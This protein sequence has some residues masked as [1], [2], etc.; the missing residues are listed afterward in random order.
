[1]NKLEFRMFGC[2]IP[3]SFWDYGKYSVYIAGS[4]FD[5]SENLTFE[6][7]HKKEKYSGTTRKG[8]ITLLEKLKNE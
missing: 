5:N 2:V 3:S 4:L 8:F 6:I 1:M 7:S